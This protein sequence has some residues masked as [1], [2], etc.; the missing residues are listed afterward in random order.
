MTLFLLQAALAVALTLPLV[1]ALRR[2]P[3]NT[4]LRT[5][6]LAL[7]RAQ[8]DE[9]ARDAAI[10]LLP[11]LEYQA[12]RLEIEH[13]LLAADQ[14][15]EPPQTG[16]AKPLLIAAMLCL[17]VAAFMLYLPGSAPNVPSEPHAT[18][19]ARYGRQYALLNELIT[20]LRAH[21]ATVDP[22]SANASEGEAY[23]GQALSERAD[24]IT[25][26]ALLLFKESL[27]SAPPGSSWIAIDKQFLDEA[28]QR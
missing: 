18:W 24:A 20:K 21:L 6:A 23:L 14:L 15:H 5:A 9:L 16:N 4:E 11:E 8:L 25:P 1:L 17:P 19:M 2:Q 28:G 12:A 26:E 7:Y 13:R 22:H 27:A 3:R 10:G